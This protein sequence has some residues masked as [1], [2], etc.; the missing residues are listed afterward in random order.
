MVNKDVHT[1]TVSATVLILMANKD[2]H[3]NT[4]SAILYVTCTADV[5]SNDSIVMYER[6]DLVYRRRLMLKLRG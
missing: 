4:V 3:T 2:V 6:Q 1:N 5:Q